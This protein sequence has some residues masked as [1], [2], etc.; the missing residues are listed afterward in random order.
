MAAKWSLAVEEQFYL[1]LPISVRKVTRSRLPRIVLL[2]VL[3]APILRIMLYSI[4]PAGPN[5][6][7]VL[8]PCRPDALL[9]GVTPWHGGRT[10]YSKRMGL[11]DNAHDDPLLF[12]DGDV[13]SLN[14]PDGGTARDES[15]QNLL[16]SE[17]PHGT[18]H[19]LLRRLSTHGPIYKTSYALLK[20]ES[21]A[22]R[23]FSDWSVTGSGHSFDGNH[24]YSFLE[25]LLKQ[26]GQA[27]TYSHLLRHLE[28]CFQTTLDERAS[29][30]LAEP[31]FSIS[32]QHS[33]NLSRNRQLHGLG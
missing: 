17:V 4:T 28:V 33:A 16:A 31:L 30:S 18:R 27:W 9:L 6:A 21:P 25:I 2:L 20:K 24:S 10:F 19:D 14:P 1:G 29:L 3:S 8:M 26:A 32:T 23:S 15:A 13:L 7:C 11:V 5:A 12:V 22:L